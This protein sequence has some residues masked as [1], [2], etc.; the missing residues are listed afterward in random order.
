MGC[1]AFSGSRTGRNDRTLIGWVAREATDGENWG[2]TQEVASMK[3]ITLAVAI[4]G[5]GI[6]SIFALNAEPA[7][8][9]QCGIKPIKPIPPIGCKDMVAECSCDASGRNCSWRW[10]CVK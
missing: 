2:F 4:V 5:L 7:C 1:R 10:V 9:G 6:G 8:A 3:W